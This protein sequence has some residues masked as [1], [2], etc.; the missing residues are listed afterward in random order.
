MARPATSSIRRRRLRREAGAFVPDTA[1]D[2]FAFTDVTGAALSTVYTSNSITVA[3]I[4]TAAAISITGGTYSVN[5]AGFVS[6]S[7]TVNNGDTVS[8]RGTSSASYSTA[9]N[10][11]VAIGGVSDSYTITTQAAP[12]NHILLEDGSGLLTESGDSLTQE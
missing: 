10:V 12:T 2:A 5:G 8:V 4:N 7:G 11:A 1:P 3:G 6:S 9:V